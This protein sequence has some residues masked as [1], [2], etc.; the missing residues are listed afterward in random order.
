MSSY[1]CYICLIR[2]QKAHSKTRFAQTQFERESP[3]DFEPG[4]GHRSP[5]ITRWLPTPSGSVRILRGGLCPPQ[6]QLDAS[7]VF[8][9]MPDQGGTAAGEAEDRARTPAL[10]S[11][12]TT[13]SRG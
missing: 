12:Q 9:R 6:I 11:A 8:C 4:V 10:Q 13:S 7:R 3:P 1:I 2:T 5:V